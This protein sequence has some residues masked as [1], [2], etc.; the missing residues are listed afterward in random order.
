MITIKVDF[1][2]YCISLF[3]QIT[4]VFFVLAYALTNKEWPVISSGCCSPIAARIVGAT[5]PKTPSVFFKLQPFGALAMMNGTLLV[6]WEVF[7][8]PSSNF[9]SSALLKGC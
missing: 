4:F 3:A 7:G 6:V 2:L 8:L 5:S 1:Y 9:I